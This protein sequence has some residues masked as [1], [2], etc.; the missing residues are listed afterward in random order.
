MSD[1]GNDYLERQTVHA[2][3][4]RGVLKARW[5][6]TP[7]LPGG[8]QAVIGAR[9]ELGLRRAGPLVFETGDLCLEY[10]SGEHYFNVIELW[11]A[12]GL[13][14][15]YVNLATP[16]VLDGADIT[17][18]DLAL[19]FAV[20]ADGTAVELDGRDFH[21][22]LRDGLPGETRRSRI[23]AAAADLRRRLAGGRGPRW[24]RSLYRRAAVHPGEEHLLDMVRTYGLPPTLFTGGPGLAVAMTDFW[25]EGMARGTR[26]AE[27]L[28][29]L[30]TGEG[31]VLLHGKSF[32]PDGILRL[33][34]GGMESG[35]RP[36]E[37][38]VREALEETSLPSRPAGFIGYMRSLLRAG[39]E[40]VPL[41]VPT[42][43]F[44]LESMDRG[45]HP[46]PQ[47]EE[48]ITVL[49]PTPAE[50]LDDVIARLHGLTGR[51]AE[52][53]RYRALQHR[54]ARRGLSLQKGS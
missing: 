10:Y 25:V 43:I 51:W 32:Y 20:T 9:W 38:A 31:D 27:A 4:P 54:V 8:G 6:G 40:G 53:G 28:F 50:R 23:L 37:A 21:Q 46:V 14:G 34:G 12:E 26:V 15:W 22:L 35:E 45:R 5:A 36:D 16:A 17:Y 44:R 18:T 39:R 47:A 41:T 29:A 11:G 30:D 13:K 52:W 3:L 49:Q 7:L 24:L 2:F 19:D 1:K 48:H 33:P 42:Y